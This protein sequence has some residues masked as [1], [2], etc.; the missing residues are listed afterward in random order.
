MGQDL[1][2]LFF[3]L[4]AFLCLFSFFVN[5]LPFINKPI[6]RRPRHT[7][8]AMFLS[9]SYRS[10]AGC[11]RNGLIVAKWGM[12]MQSSILPS[13][14]GFLCPSHSAV[15]TIVHLCLHV[16]VFHNVAFTATSLD[17]HCSILRHFSVFAVLKF[18][19]HMNYFSNRV[20]FSYCRYAPFSI[21][22]FFYGRTTML[23]RKLL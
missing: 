20:S 19:S 11:H 22:R 13:A 17:Y 8:S 7:H 18:C 10:A 9:P 21:S 6:A 16:H 12:L 23:Q 5:T 3:P 4:F 2:T 14:V 15:C 1:W